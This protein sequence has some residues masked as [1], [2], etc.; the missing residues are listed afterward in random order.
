[1]EGKKMKKVLSILVALV[2]MLG[3][4]SAVAE[5]PAVKI[6]VAF[7]QIDQAAL[8]VQDYLQNYVSPQ[9]NVTFMFSEAIDNVDKLINFMD[10]AYA[11]GCQGIMNYQN[12]SV[13]QAISKALELE[14]YIA[15]NTTTAVENGDIPFNM[16]MAA[17]DAQYCA[18]QFGDMV[19]GLF[20]DGEIHNVVIVSAGAGMGNNEHKYSTMA[21]L[22]MLQNI[23]GL[24]YEQ[25]IETMATTRSQIDCAN[26][27]GVLITIYPGYPTGDTYVP[28]MS[29]ILQTGKYDTVLAC[30]AAYAKFSVAIDEVEKSTGKNIRVSAITAINDTTKSGFNT[31]D[32]T[33][34]HSL[35][36]AILMPSV[37]TASA[38]FALVYNGITGYADQFRQDDMGYYY[39]SPKWVCPDAESYA[40]LE[41]I[42]SSEDT[43]EVNI[44][45]L[46]QMLAL[47]NPDANLESLQELMLKMDA[48]YILE[49]RGL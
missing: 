38:L 26:D 19:S 44:E 17:A 12:S 34:N 13:E 40:R 21:I 28:G 6:A 23:Y 18:N 31:I 7:Y 32:S 29:T 30:N 15:T 4:F 14:M 16:G 39:N 2:M 1:M 45:E 24:T 49:A 42:N 37:S 27:K 20:S 10:S 9:L 5:A 8:Q 25:D 36:S 3:C 46:K 33:G 47:Y 35:D 11:A 41:K 48:N 43:W 22:E